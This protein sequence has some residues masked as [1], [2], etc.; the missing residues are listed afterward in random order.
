LA[1][2]FLAD[3]DLVVVDHFV[4]R[5][6]L[7]ETVEVLLGLEP[8]VLA[9]RLVVEAQFVEVIRAA[10][11]GRTRTDAAH[12]ALRRQL[13]GRLVVAVVDAAG[14]QR[15]IGIAF[16]KTDQHLVADARCRDHPV[17][18]CSPRRREADEAGAALVLRADPVPA[19][20]D[21]DTA[22][23]VDMDLVARRAGRPPR[24]AALA[25]STWE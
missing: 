13:V 5:V 8:H 18:P 23:P 6:V 21:L 14:D 19:E 1:T 9:A 16:E 4:G 17:S 24:S 25:R 15:P 2:W 10:A 22:E 7:D 3:L 20:P 12:A 11:L